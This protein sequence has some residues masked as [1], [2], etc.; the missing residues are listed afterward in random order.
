MSI[1]EKPLPNNYKLTELILQTPKIK[2]TRTTLMG[3][4]VKKY[5]FKLNT[6]NWY[7]FI[8]YK[9]ILLSLILLILL[10]LKVNLILNL[11]LN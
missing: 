8:I 3:G 5:K 9:L 7:K 6:F 10:N 4:Q 2:I 1:L 11:N